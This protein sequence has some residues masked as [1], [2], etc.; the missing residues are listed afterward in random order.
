MK[1]SGPSRTGLS[2]RSIALLRTMLK[3][4]FVSLLCVTATTASAGLDVT[5]YTQLSIVA[6]PKLTTD[7][8]PVSPNEFVLSAGPF[9]ERFSGLS[10]GKVYT[11]PGSFEFRAGSYSGYNNWRNELAKLAGYAPTP[12]DIGG[13]TRTRYDATAWKL[14]QGP[15]WELINFSDSEGVIGPDVCKKVYQDFVAYDDAASRHA[16]PG[17]RELYA[18]WEKAFRLC[19]DQGAIV[20]H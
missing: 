6:S 3:A 10:D 18:D 16:D 15:F 12:V 1:V 8:E 19:A 17:F 11:A 2:T 7:G 20:F 9:P 5:A 4:C 14:R 13:M